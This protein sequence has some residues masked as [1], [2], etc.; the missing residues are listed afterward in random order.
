MAPYQVIVVGGGAA[1]M[2]AAGRAAERGKR[3]LLLEKNARL[4]EKLR[5][6]G[7]GRCNILNAEEDAHVLLRHYGSAERFLRSPFSQ[8]GMREAYAFFE[9]HALPL[10][11]AAKK[12][13][14]P[15]SE[16]AAD[17]VRTLAEYMKRGGVTVRL[18]APVERLVAERGRIRGVVAGGEEYR[19]ESFIL[20]TGG[21]SHPETGSTGDGF[22]WLEA[23]G[24]T[25]HAPT[26][27]I[28]PLRAP[29]KWIEQLSGKTLPAVK[30]SFF[31][32]GTRA[33]AVRGDVL[34]THFGLSGPCILNAAGRVADLLQSGS[35]TAE[36]DT[37]PD[38]DLGILEK[39]ITAIFDANK[40]KALKNVFKEIAP[41]GTGAVLLAL[42]TGV[43]PEKKV[44]SI[45]KEER[46]ALTTILKALPVC[47]AGLMGFDRAVVAD[48][49]LTLTE[50]DTKT[51]RT[52]AYDNL[53][54]T[55]DLLHISRPSGGYSLQLAWTSGYV[56]GS[57]A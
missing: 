36:I 32:D 22:A 44:H 7:G 35:V 57:Y 19:A 28:V 14:F 40:N 39:R 55:G 24:C 20:A 23:L 26:P 49:G 50:I 25:V 18:G 1:G 34:C 30:V 5:I 56:A 21:V 16:Q 37:Y 6:S 48:G 31:A 11:V 12:R 47:I 38:L 29:E 53:F 8:F 9:T 42:A 17:V 33:F 27:T 52:H 4:G 45:T 13:A 51:M 10:M 54:V 3:V 2:M 15:Q 43:D 41:R 46:R